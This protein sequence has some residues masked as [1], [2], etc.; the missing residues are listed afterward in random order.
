MITIYH[1]PRC[2]KSR[3]V[4]Q[5]LEDSGKEFEIVRYLDETLNKNQLNEIITI[6]GIKPLD[7]VRSNEAIWKTEY[8][9]KPLSDDAVIDAMVNH[10]K[11]IERPIV[12]NNKKG[13][14]G[15]PPSD[16]LSII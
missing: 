2:R 10:P 4:L 6:L 11:L 3:E 13:V 14:I 15:R 8:K 5:L 7:L 16:I 9:G 12:T 1:N